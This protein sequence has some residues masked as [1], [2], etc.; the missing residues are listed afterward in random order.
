MMSEAIA[1]PAKATEVIE[2][3][4]QVAHSG[5]DYRSLP[6][7]FSDALNVHEETDERITLALTTLADQRESVIMCFVGPYGAKRVS[8]YQTRSASIDLLD[9]LSVE[10]VICEVQKRVAKEKP[11][12]ILLL[13]SFGGAVNSSYTIAKMLRESFSDVTVCIPHIAASGGTLIALGGNRIV[14]G[15]NSR[16]SPLDTQV[17]YKAGRVSA[18]SIDRAIE[19]LEKLLEKK[20]V[21]EIAHVYR[22]MMEKLD[23]VLWEEWK[24]SLY[25]MGSYAR[26]IL[27]SAGY[28]KKKI[29]KMI[30]YLIWTPFPHDYYIGRDRASELLQLNVVNDDEDPDVWMVLKSWHSLYALTHEDRHIVRYAFPKAL[31]AK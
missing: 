2:A 12:L 27:T 9:E 28:D 4:Q 1:T 19:T 23:P 18:Q 29:D 8:A 11:K 16:L 31:R 20:R 22:E 25:Q 6:D 15:M 17:P 26:E 24:A 5:I 7:G 14:L 3:A 21:D 13:S 10:R 30:F